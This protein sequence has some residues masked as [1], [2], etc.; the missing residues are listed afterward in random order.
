MTSYRLSI[1]S[2]VAVLT[3]AVA[4]CGTSTEVP[5]SND[6][7]RTVSVGVIPIIDVAPLYLGRKKGF[8]EAHKIDLK[9]KEMQGGSAIL[10]S[11]VSGELQYGFSNNT[12]LL[13]AANEG[14]PI[15]IIANGV[16]STGKRGDDYYAVIAGA[17]TPI[18]D[19]TDLSAHTVA[20]N[21][22]TNISYTAVRESVRQAGGNV[23]NINFVEIRYPDMPS[24]VRTGRVDAAAI[25]EPFLSTA[26]KNG[27]KT[28]ASP[29][30][31]IK[32]NLMVSS[33]F[34]TAQFAQER[35][36]LAE[37]FRAAVNRSFA[38]AREHPEEVRETL[39]R[40][41]EIPEEL[42]Q[43]LTLPEWDTRIDRSSLRRLASLALEDGLI[44]KKP[45]TKKLIWDKREN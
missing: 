9:L 16:E 45:S 44:N 8:F 3:L 10:P 11:V 2:M 14:L 15:R 21:T 37:D 42:S 24:V 20:V 4:A 40:Y 1:P 28:I 35:P 33:Y 18:S 13:I 22:V 34:T 26:N 6:A 5:A 19:A 41:T 23:A 25:A 32:P 39:A 30:V 12:S 38:Y 31:D 29:F 17:D 43:Q 7:P 36:Q 27:A